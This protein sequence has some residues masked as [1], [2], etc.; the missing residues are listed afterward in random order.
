MEM[1]V[2]MRVAEEPRWLSHVEDKSTSDPFATSE[3]VTDPVVYKLVRVDND[4]RLIPATD[5]ELME[6]EDLLEYDKDES[7]SLVEAAQNVDSW[8]DKYK[9]PRNSMSEGYEGSMQCD[10]IEVSVEKS[11]AQV[12]NIGE[13]LQKVN[14]EEKLQLQF[15]SPFHFS[16]CM[17]V[18]N[19]TSQRDK[20]PKSC[21]RARSRI[22][23]QEILPALSL[24]AKGRP[25]D[26]S[27]QSAESAN[28]EEEVR[29]NQ[30]SDSVLASSKPNF[31]RLKGDLDL[32]NLTM[33]ELQETFLATFGRKTT[34]KDKQWLKR[35]IAMGLT[36]S[37]VVPLT[38]F[39]IQGKKIVKKVDE[40]R[41]AAVGLEDPVHG[42]VYDSGKDS[43][44]LNENKTGDAVVEIKQRSTSPESD[45]NDTS[46][47]K[48]SSKRVRKPTRRYIEE[49][50]DSGTPEYLGRLT[51]SAKRSGQVNASDVNMGF[52]NQLEQDIMSSNSTVSPSP[53]SNAVVTR[54]DSLGGTGIQVPCVSRLRRCRPRKSI[55]ALTRFQPSG[56]EM[57]TK[58]IENGL[59]HNLQLA[60]ASQDEMLE[61]GCCN[62]QPDKTRDSEILEVDHFGSDLDDASKDKVVEALPAPS[63]DSPTEIKKANEMRFTSGHELGEDQDP[64]HTDSSGHD[65]D[66]VLSPGAK[67]GSTRR[68][69]HRA[70]TLTEVVK[71]VDGVAKFGPGKWSEIKRLS[72]SSVAYRTSVDLKDK[73]RNLLKASF[74]ALP[75]Q[76]G[77]NPQKNGSAP[78]PVPILL[79]VRELAKLNGQLPK[80]QLKPC[81][82]S[83]TVKEDGNVNESRSGFL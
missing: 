46:H 48:G 4:G 79:K 32:E 71:L 82:E 16:G 23:L 20:R 57:S 30:T 27:G 8:P 42:V 25:D 62:S 43:L 37:C 50:S 68:K 5:D 1:V 80:L 70:W 7:C 75:S 11:N 2:G 83:R 28:L 24:A 66:V 15:E 81:K 44:V 10:T 13:V 76:T 6:V 19:E 38:T 9:L 21:E 67:G 74:A 41:V 17:D 54:H 3:K 58:S 59:G 69:H 64:R 33:R 22:S 55:M 40:D 18:D 56:T 51:S 34:V 73:W 78:L 12:K 72:F 14:E 39:I 53:E 47:E 63:K 29:H 65:T 36:N 35:R 49:L 77:G 61:D 45:N 31:S 26:Q 52:A 60:K